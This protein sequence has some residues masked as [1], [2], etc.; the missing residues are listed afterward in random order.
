MGKRIGINDKK[1][2]KKSYF[3]DFV[4]DTEKKQVSIRKTFL[5]SAEIIDRI[6]KYIYEKR[7]SGDI[8]Y[9]KTDLVNDAL[10]KFLNI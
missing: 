8:Y 1:E 9:S 7:T 5:I 4:S 2:S 6:E 10:K 3:D